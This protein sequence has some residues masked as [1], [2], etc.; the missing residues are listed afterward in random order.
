MT[1]KQVA[2]L[3]GVSVRTLQ[4]YDEIGLFKPT[5]TSEAGYRLYDEAAITASGARGAAAVYYNDIYVPVEYSMET[6]ALMPG[7]TPF[8]TSGHEHSGLRSGDVLPHLFDVAAGR[9]V[10]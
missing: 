1:V 5:A 10:R 2:S 9:L 6:A 7:V 8:V 3:T 4:F